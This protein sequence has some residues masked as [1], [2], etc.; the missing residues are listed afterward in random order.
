[1]HGCGDRD[2]HPDQRGA[3]HHLTLQ[4]LQ[5]ARPAVRQVLDSRR[6]VDVPLTLVACDRLL[7]AQRLDEATEIWNRLAAEHRIPFPA[8]THTAA[9]TTFG[10]AIAASSRSACDVN[11]F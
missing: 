11:Q 2:G 10:G 3:A 8:L 5:L 4:G 1:M 9:V 7:D 6:P